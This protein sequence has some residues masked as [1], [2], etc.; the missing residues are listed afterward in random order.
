M[1]KSVLVFEVL[2]W[3]EVVNREGACG[4]SKGPFVAEEPGSQE[5]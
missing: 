2:L 4:E 3:G 1:M 5:V